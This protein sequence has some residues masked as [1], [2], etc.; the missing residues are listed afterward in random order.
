LF[1]VAFSNKR[2]V[3]KK[4]EM[5]S[6]NDLPEYDKVSSLPSYQEAT[7]HVFIDSD[8]LLLSFSEEK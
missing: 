8:S 1:Y 5:I 7:Q 2:F 4:K 6:T 3:E